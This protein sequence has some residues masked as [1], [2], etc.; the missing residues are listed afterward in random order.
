MKKRKRVGRGFRRNEGKKSRRVRMCKLSL[1][2][3]LRRMA[4]RGE[5]VET[6]DGK[7]ELPIMLTPP[8]K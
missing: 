6:P 4:K 5:V 1:K 2:A 3:L 8:S 7:W